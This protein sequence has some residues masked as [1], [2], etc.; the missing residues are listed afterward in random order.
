MYN[1]L[2][3]K[4]YIVIFINSIIT[5]VLTG[6]IGLLLSFLL[7]AY[8]GYTTTPP[9]FYYFA[10]IIPI[11]VLGPYCILVHKMISRFYSKGNMSKKLFN[12]INIAIPTGVLAIMYC[13]LIY[14]FIELHI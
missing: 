10:G 9:S 13:G 6:V 5:I 12:T 4:S 11:V 8:N 7:I 3:M 1:K 2:S 14:I